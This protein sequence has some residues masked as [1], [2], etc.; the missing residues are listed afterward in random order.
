MA[1]CSLILAGFRIVYID[2]IEIYQAVV[3][4]TNPVATFSLEANM[5]DTS[6][7]VAFTG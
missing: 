7:I 5:A 1:H 3:T 6:K 2:D 4:Q